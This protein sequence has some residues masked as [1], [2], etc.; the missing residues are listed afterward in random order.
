LTWLDPAGVVVCLFHIESLLFLTPPLA[1]RPRIAII[2]QV[3]VEF[4]IDPLS[5]TFVGEPEVNDPIDGWDSDDI[6]Y[7]DFEILSSE[8]GSDSED[9]WDDLCVSDVEVECTSRARPKG[10][11]KAKSYAAALAR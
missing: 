10:K 4:D 8:T 6:D 3:P 11:Q 2:K 1:K 5:W 9:Y 7:D